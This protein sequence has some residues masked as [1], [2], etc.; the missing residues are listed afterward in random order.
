MCQLLWILKVDC[1]GSFR[2]VFVID[3]Q[4]SPSDARKKQGKCLKC[5]LSK[6]IAWTFAKDN[7]IVT[8]FSLGVFSL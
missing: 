8:A 5:C 4:F 1:L 6:F 7:L 2:Y 3:M